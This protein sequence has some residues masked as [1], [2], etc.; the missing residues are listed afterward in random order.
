MKAIKDLVEGND[1]RGALDDARLAVEKFLK[2][3]FKNG[4]NLSNQVAEIGQD[5]NRKGFN[6]ELV[7]LYKWFD[8]YQN[9]NVKH[10]FDN[11]PYEEMEFMIFMACSLI[12]LLSK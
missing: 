10:D 11:M 2:I 6:N 3:K 12:N 1:K 5:L 9:E 4:K 7:S 8:K